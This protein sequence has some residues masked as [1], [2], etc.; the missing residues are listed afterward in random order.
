MELEVELDKKAPTLNTVSP[1]PKFLVGYTPSPGDTMLGPHITA[2]SIC[3]D[4]MDKQ[5]GRALAAL[6]SL[7]S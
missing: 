4:Q 7:V 5:F 3:S 1:G 2:F 6:C